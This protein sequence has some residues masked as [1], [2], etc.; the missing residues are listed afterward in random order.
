MKHEKGELYLVNLQNSETGATFYI[1][2][3]K[4]QEFYHYAQIS[5]QDNRYIIILPLDQSKEFAKCEMTT[6]TLQGKQFDAWKLDDEYSVIRV[7][8]HDGEITFYQYDSLD[9]TLQRYAKPVAQKVEEEE[10]EF[11]F[12]SFLEKYHL[13]V[14]A[15]L[16]ALVLILATILIYFLGTKNHRHQVRRQRLQKRLEKRREE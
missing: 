12:L 9:G 2:D 4:T 11:T 3:Q 1:Y 15:G 14:I 16:S 7:M 13:Y 10:K 8:N 6:L 5:F